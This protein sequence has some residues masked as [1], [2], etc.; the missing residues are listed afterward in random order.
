M[1]HLHLEK[2]LVDIL[3]EHPQGL[4]EYQLIGILQQPP[5]EVFDKTALS[6]TLTLFQ[7][8]FVLFHSLYQLRAQGLRAKQYDLQI[9]ATDIKFLPYV[10]EGVGL[11]AVDKLQ[12]YYLDWQ[13][14]AVTTE[15]DVETLLSQFWYAMTGGKKNLSIDDAVLSKITE[16][17]KAFE[18]PMDSKMSVVKSTYLHLQHR[19]HPDKGGD[20]KRSQQLEAQFQLIKDYLRQ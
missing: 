11:A 7:S 14:F 20:K 6:E 16:A 10:S 12:N 8:H 17:Y 1:Q 19:H 4:S 13:N 15:Q 3:S 9:F 5:Y 2:Y 18:L